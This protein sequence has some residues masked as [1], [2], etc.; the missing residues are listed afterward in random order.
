MTALLEK[1]KEKSTIVGIL[2]LG[3]TVAGYTFTPEQ[4][5]AIATAAASFAAVALIYIK[6]HKA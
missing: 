6:E 2:T 1:L 4:A 3:A 5:D